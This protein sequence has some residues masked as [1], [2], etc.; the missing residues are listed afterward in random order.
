MEVTVLAEGVLKA[1]FYGFGT[2][3]VLGTLG[4][5]VYMIRQSMLYKDLVVIRFLDKNGNIQ[6]QLD[7]GGVFKDYKT[8]NKLYRLKGAKHQIGINV[9]NVEHTTGGKRLVELFRKDRNTYCSF[10]ERIIDETKL[11]VLVNDGDVDWAINQ[12]D[13][14][15]K[16]FAASNF[17]QLL[18]YIGI[19]LMFL[20]LIVIGIYLIKA[21]P[22][23]I[24]GINA[25]AQ[26]LAEA[27]KAQAGIIE[28]K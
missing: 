19:T 27:T 1:L 20:G 10:D 23:L 16:T 12:F 13:S 7:R 17:M 26:N 22:E 6:K 4:G 9:V 18:P 21:Y 25:A 3:M 8:R 24:N 28:T 14:Y 2:L 15:K 5:V 11:D